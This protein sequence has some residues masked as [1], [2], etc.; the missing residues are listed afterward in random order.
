MPQNA[1]FAQLSALSATPAQVVFVKLGSQM[2]A[3]S[4]ISESGAGSP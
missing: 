4:F 2:M 1:V 3:Y